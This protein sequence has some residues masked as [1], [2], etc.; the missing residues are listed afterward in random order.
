ME[1]KGMKIAIG[2]TIAAAGLAAGIMR[3]AAVDHLAKIAFDRDCPRI[4]TQRS[5]NRLTG[6]DADQAF[7]SVLSHYAHRLRKKDM[8]TVRIHAKDGETLVGHWFYN[9]SSKRVVIAMHGWR[10][11]WD[12]DF[13]MVADFLQRNG[14]SVLYAEQRGQNASG[15]NRIGFGVLERF[16]CLDWI[17]WVISQV[18]EALPIYLIGI[19][20]GATTVMLAS[21]LKLPRQVKGIIADCGFTSIHDISQHVLKNNLRLHYGVGSRTV[22]S[23]CR[24]RLHVGAKDYSTVSALKHSTVP[25][26]LVHG[27]G[28]CFVPVSMTYE[29]YQACASPKDMLI[30][31]HADHG[32]SYFL[33]RQRYESAV[34]DFWNKYD[35]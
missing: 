24:K 25:V 4:P 31:P 22:D 13:G 12:H 15:G 9:P 6:S 8:Q 19:S 17:R 14:C 1:K 10:S 11:S 26:L 32:M 16:D 27:E 5:R 23:L 30:I 28:D 7:Q 34:K 20:M 21:E 2:S 35:H 3:Y 18:G 29:N 33:D